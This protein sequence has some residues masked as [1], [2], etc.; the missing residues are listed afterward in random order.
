MYT[1]RPDATDKERIA[2]IEQMVGDLTSQLLGNG[3]PGKLAHIDNRL[4][5]QDERIITLEKWRSGW[6]GVMTAIGV[7][8]SIG[9]AIAAIKLAINLLQHS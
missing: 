7:L 9:G 3:Q 4:E 6:G 2:V 5:K 8:A 1:P